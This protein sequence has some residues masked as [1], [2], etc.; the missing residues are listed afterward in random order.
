[1]SSWW[2]AL[3]I[4]TQLVVFMTLVISLIEAGTLLSI[5]QLD[6]KE[7]E[8]FAMD[9]V[10]TVT[11]SLNND[12]LQAPLAPSAAAF[13]DINHRISGFK[14]I[15][16]MI[17]LDSDHNAIMHYGQVE[18][19]SV[20][21]QS[22][23]HSHFIFA[24]NRLYSKTPIIAENHTFGYTLL[25]V[26]LTQHREAQRQGFYILL[27]LFPIALLVGLLV[28]WWVSL[29]F[30]RPFS[31]LANAMETHELC[32][33]Q[34]LDIENTK[35]NEVGQLFKGYNKMLHRVEL[36]AQQLR[37]QSQ[38]DSLT[39]LYNRFYMEEEIKRVLKGQWLGHSAL[40]VLDLDQFNIINNR[41]GF[42]AGDEL[43]KMIANHC[44]N[45]IPNNVCIARVGGDD[46]YLL[47]E[48]VK[49]DT[50][51]A[52]LDHLTRTL[53]DFR[54]SWEGQVYSVSASMGAVLFKPNQYTL[55][56]LVKAAYGAFHAAKLKGR[57]KFEIYREEGG[58]RYLYDYDLKMA[59]AIKE[60]ITEGPARFELFAQPIVPLQS[61]SSQF[62]YEI[63]IRMYGANGELISPDEFLPTAERYQL[64]ADIDMYVL[65]RYLE[66][67]SENP[68]HV[69]GLHK[70]HVNLA[71]ASL[72]NL[73]FQTKLKSAVT[74]FEFPWHKLEL[75]ITE[76][77]AVGNFTK[78]KSF[79]EYCRGMGIGMA[80]DDFG[81]GMSSFE[82]LKCLP[83]DVIKI[84]GSFV[85]DMHADPT[86]LA[87]IRYI[88][89]ISELRKQETVAE[90]VETQE[91]VDT[92]RD[93]GITYGQGYF[94]GKPKP[95]T[96]WFTD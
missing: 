3:S 23:F 78:A 82:Y 4:R 26:D 48:G 42:L 64:M 94:L 91:D 14:Q 60:A 55:E 69:A 41:A 62:S 43:L 10:Q 70:A 13:A 85:K 87:V 88:Q 54:F 65:W 59:S 72:N 96:T 30:T 81:T 45:L 15:R 19:L 79:I 17:I 1:M 89:E 24:G 71:G 18:G 46:F 86:D 51:E 2:N 38:H 83:F 36:S 95:L 50:L 35:A 44:N 37:F 57:G 58:E 93:I 80:L 29:N 66:L 6:K 32:D 9:V 67:V 21:E 49:H 8:R 28:S 84:D 20:Q 7:S 5:H 22:L 27:A 77:S 31:R 34:Y 61:E 53:S 76:T 16:G 52:L 68:E 92:L 90:Y 25:D 33:G 47:A 11:T 56:N 40:I 39:G 63:L 75:E 74:H 73:D 12:L